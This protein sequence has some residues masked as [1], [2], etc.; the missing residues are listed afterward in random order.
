MKNFVQAGEML[1]AAAP[2][3]GVSSG[4]PVLIGAIF[5]VAATDAAEGANVE[6][7][8]LGVFVMPKATGETW[9][10]GD[11][12]YYDSVAKKLTKTASTSD[13]TLV[14]VAVAVAGSSDVTGSA[15]I[16]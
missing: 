11:E 7:A 2:S 6:I 14:A 8:T 10:F 12:L 13:S 1:T 4:D 15:K 5:G 3:G 16:I 9:S